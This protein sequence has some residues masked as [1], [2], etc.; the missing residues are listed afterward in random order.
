MP[1]TTSGERQYALLPKAQRALSGAHQSGLCTHG[2]CTNTKAG[3]LHRHRTGT[4][5]THTRLHEHETLSAAHGGLASVHGRCGRISCQHEPVLQL[6][7]QELRRNT[8][9]MTTGAFCPRCHAPRAAP[10]A[11]GRHRRG[12]RPRASRCRGAK[13]LPCCAG[14]WYAG[15]A[16]ARRPAAPVRAAPCWPTAHRKHRTTQINSRCPGPRR[17]RTAIAAHAGV[18]RLGPAGVAARHAVLRVRGHA[19]LGMRGHAVLRLRPRM[20]HRRGTVRLRARTRVR[21]RQAHRQPRMPPLC[22]HGA[23]SA[24]RAAGAGSPAAARS[25]PAVARRSAAPAAARK[26]AAPAARRGT[27][28]RRDM[29]RRRSRPARPAAVRA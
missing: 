21:C 2:A 18:G 15:C 16:P 14:C 7:Q 23:A 17:A 13:R 28:P 4:R 12:S 29:S 24:R 11:P 25:T 26:H 22:G 20:V 19:I 6:I 27:A 3:L 10:A 5:G 1:D 8:V 9:T